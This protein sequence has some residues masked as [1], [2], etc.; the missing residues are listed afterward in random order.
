M[1]VSGRP[2]E[3]K[4][5]EHRVGMY[6]NT[7]AFKAVVDE[8]QET[9]SW[10][11]GLQ[12]DQVSSR[13]YQYT[14]LQDVQGWTGIKGDLFDSLLVFENYPVTTGRFQGTAHCQL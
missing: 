6:I 8:Q 1:V 7:L 4:G 12:A 9:V 5:V 2:V 10:L 13:Q 11:Q 14:P 3:L